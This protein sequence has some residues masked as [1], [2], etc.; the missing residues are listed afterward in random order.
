MPSLS[1]SLSLSL[2]FSLPVFPFY[3]FQLGLFSFSFLTSLISSFPFGLP[4]VQLLFHKLGK[5]TQHLVRTHIVERRRDHVGETTSFPITAAFTRKGQTE[6][7]E[8]SGVHANENTNEAEFCGFREEGEVGVKPARLPAAAVAP[9]TVVQL[10]HPATF[11][12]PAFD[13]PSPPMLTT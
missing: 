13:S 2:S 8:R 4:Y 11:H 5:G 1:L 3:R 6:G 7:G 12:S 10:L 9:N